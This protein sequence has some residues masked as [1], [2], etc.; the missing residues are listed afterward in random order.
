MDWVLPLQCQNCY[1]VC[2]RRMQKNNRTHRPPFL[3]GQ[4]PGAKDAHTA[5]QRCCSASHH[6][7]RSTRNTEHSSPAPP[8]DP[9]TIVHYHTAQHNTHTNTGRRSEPH[10]AS[11]GPPRG[12]P[13]AA[14]RGA[15]TRTAPRPPRSAGYA[16][17]CDIALSGGIT[18]A[19]KVL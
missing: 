19:F 6:C 5:P 9:C 14:P 12:L 10:S 4:A 17:V 2:Y 8:H 15:R 16:I 11:P 1:C 7:Y 18:V 3:P 13:G